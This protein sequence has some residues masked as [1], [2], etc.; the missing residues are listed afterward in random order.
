[1][2][3]LLRNAIRQGHPARK[4]T[5]L[6][7]LVIL[8]MAAVAVPFAL[9]AQAMA[10]DYTESPPLHH[11]FRGFYDSAF[12]P[13]FPYSFNPF[14]EELTEEMD[15]DPLKFSD[16]NRSMFT[17]VGPG[18]YAGHRFVF[19]ISEDLASIGQI[20]ILHEGYSE[21]GGHTLYVWNNTS[22]TWE[23]LDTTVVTVPDQTLTGTIAGNFAQ[24]ITGGELSVLALGNNPIT[25]YEIR[26]DY[27]RV[28]VTMGQPT[29][30]EGAWYYPP[31]KVVTTG[32]KNITDSSA[33]ITGEL[34]EKG[35]AN[36]VDVFFKY[37]TTHDQA[38]YPLWVGG[39][40]L[41][42]DTKYYFRAVAIGDGSFYG[43]MMTFT[44][45]HYMQINMTGQT[46][47]I[48][49]SGSGEVQESLT[50]TSGDGSFELT[51]P[52]GT[53][54][55][56]KDGNPLQSI[57]ISAATDVPNPPPGTGI[58]GF[59]YDCQPAGATFNPPL[60][61]TMHYDPAN[62]PEGATEDSLSIALWDGTQWV[63]LQGTVDTVN[64]TVTVQISHFSGFALLSRLPAPLPPSGGFVVS[65][66]S[67]KPS[68]AAPDQTVTI[69]AMVVNNATCEGQCNVC[70]KIN[71]TE[72]AVQ[73]LT[74]APGTGETVTFT[75]SRSAAATYRV[76]VN[77]LTGSFVVKAA[78]AKSQPPTA[79]AA[80][81]PEDATKPPAAAVPAAPTAT[82]APLP[83]PP[84]SGAFSWWW[85]IVI[86]A[87][88]AIIGWGILRFARKRD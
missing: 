65:G 23:Q 12:A 20:S 29:T 9:V 67:I 72:E 5:I 36:K 71:G 7:P 74:V 16:D 41:A 53:T 32:F 73:K 55:L 38:T 8:V 19:D 68:T 2:S 75:T 78:P 42:P 47:S 35:S 62:L 85:I 22:T 37:G 61:L 84:E 43:D 70:C 49:S 86:I 44:T 50:V 69:S 4:R 83:I 87:A 6:I 13:N 3:G 80:A 58:I 81:R 27:V 64:H 1:M 82:P 59:I 77:G 63:I 33:T 25:W 66:L 57:S 51:I 11:F 88:V 54:A 56:D 31:P 46:S 40:D 30:Q 15:Y 18:F 17:A 21:T 28:D 26:T 52:A 10:Y 34:I 24:Y 45:G 60:T 76:D 79:A 39:N 48:Y 14:E